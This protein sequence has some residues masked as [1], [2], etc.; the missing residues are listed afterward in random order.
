[1]QYAERLPNSRTL[2][3]PVLAL[4]VGAAA[5]TGAYAL[6]DSETVVVGDPEVIVAEVPA[7]GTVAQT[8]NEAATAAAITASPTVAETKN[9]AATAAAITASPTVPAR[10]GHPSHGGTDEAATAAAIAPPPESAP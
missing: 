1:M 2:L 10:A 5:A 3:A 8:K 7:P 4:A 6:L 9:E